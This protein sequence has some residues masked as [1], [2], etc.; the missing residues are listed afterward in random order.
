MTPAGTF[1]TKQTGNPTAMCQNQMYLF[2]LGHLDQGFSDFSACRNHL[3]KLLKQTAG[4][5]LQ[6]F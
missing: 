4:P 6:R 2:S 3:E 1:C 5:L